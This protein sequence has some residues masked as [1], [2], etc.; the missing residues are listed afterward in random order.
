M[1]TKAGAQLSLFDSKSAKR[2]SVRGRRRRGHRG[3]THKRR[4]ELS[5]RHPVHVVL[6]TVR[7]VGN[8]RRRRIY[9]AF[10]WATHT[11]AKRENFRIIHLS[12]QRTH[13]HMLVEADHKYAL[14]RGMQGFAISAAKH[15]NAALSEG[16]NARHGRVFAERYYAQI[17]TSPTQACH[18]LAYVISNWR[19][20]R[21]DRT[22][23]TR[24]WHIDWFS[25]AVMFP[26][27]TEYGDDPFLWRG[28]PTYDPLLVFRPRTWLLREGWKKVSPSISCYDVP[29]SG[30]RP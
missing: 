22:A 5:A 13:V 9:H 21:E 11:A 14:S 3:A 7:E 19:K 17:I 26:D 16:P 24:D 15:I 12:I 27:W 18:A 23:E 25:S 30:G 2:R 28:P 20:H 10:R 4:P 6:R 1:R 8:L 29:S